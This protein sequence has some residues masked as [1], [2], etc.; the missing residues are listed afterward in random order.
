MEGYGLDAY[1]YLPVLGDACENLPREVN[2]SPG[3]LD[4]TVDFEDDI[5]Q[6]GDSL[7]T[8][9]PGAETFETLSR[10]AL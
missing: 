10:K 4:S 1:L 3:N 5:F 6:M 2:N 9:Y 7:K 8:A